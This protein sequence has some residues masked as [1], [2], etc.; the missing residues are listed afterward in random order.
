MS[1]PA[2][3]RDGLIVKAHSGF[4]TVRAE[5][6]LEYIG[7]L[8]GRLKK[9]QRQSDLAT[10]GDRVTFT[11]LPDGSAAIESILP[12][13]RVLSRRI[14]NGRRESEQIIV[15]NPDQAIF[16][17]ACAQPTPHLRMLDRFLVAAER[18]SLPAIICANKADLVDPAQAELIFGLYRPVGYQV[19]FTSAQTGQGIEDLRSCL[20]GKL[21][22]FSGPSGVG[23]SSLL[24]AIQPGLGLRVQTISDSRQEGRHTTVTPEL[25]PVEDGG[26]VA[27][28]PGLRAIAFWDI[29][30][31]ELDGYFPEIRPWVEKCAFN[32]CT[33]EATPGCAVKQAV[34]RGVISTERYDSFLHLRKGEA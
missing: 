14:T 29:E 26:F 32:D 6:G 23:K 2:D 20:R 25:I 10:I 13:E 8:R 34:E 11:L 30:P 7:Q 15:A 27:D 4:F 31:E 9:T 1:T 22:V 16:V 28:T 19:L 5:T 21:T 12:R 3:F 17:F 33:H 18:A 24:N